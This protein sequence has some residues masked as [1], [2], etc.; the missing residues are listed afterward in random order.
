MSANTHRVAVYGPLRRGKSN[1]ALLVDQQ[2]IGRTTLTAITLYD[3]GE[4]PGAKLEQSDG[5]VVEIY[6]VS[7]EVMQQLDQFEDYDPEQPSHGLY[8]RKRL[9]TSFGLAWVY[10]YNPEVQGAKPIRA[11]AW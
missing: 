1:H 8:D 3:L 6:D 2:F 11:G 10:L 7:P 9:H 5:V 4:Y